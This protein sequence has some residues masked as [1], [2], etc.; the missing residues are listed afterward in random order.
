[1]AMII[2]DAGDGEIIE[3]FID[4][5]ELEDEQDEIVNA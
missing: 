3:P 5:K 2:E 4:D 1:M